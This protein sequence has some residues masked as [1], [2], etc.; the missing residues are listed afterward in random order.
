MLT[1]TSYQICIHYKQRKDTWNHNSHCF[2]SNALKIIFRHFEI[3]L[4][5][6]LFS[7]F[8]C[9]SIKSSIFL[10]RSTIFVVIYTWLLACTAN[11]LG[12][13]HC[14]AGSSNLKM[15]G[16]YKTTELIHAFGERNHN[17]RKKKI[18]IWYGR[19]Q[20][21]Y[22]STEIWFTFQRNVLYTFPPTIS[23]FFSF[24]FLFNEILKPFSL[25]YLYNTEELKQKFLAKF[26][27][28]FLLASCSD[29][30]IK[31]Q[32]QSNWIIT[33]KPMCNVSTKQNV[34]SNLMEKKFNKTRIK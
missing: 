10:R 14:R 16:K 6:D 30:G 11:K 32:G 34:S 23:T 22:I 20:H 12:V 33:I 1:I 3:S 24:F 31:W 2:N 13:I 9:Y 29:Y 27:V 26:K 18:E 17:R 28:Y 19:N 5:H 8:D 4:P 25:L 21:Y 7:Y 15:R